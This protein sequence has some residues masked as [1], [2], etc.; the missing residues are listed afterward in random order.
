MPGGA[1]FPRIRADRSASPG[2]AGTTSRRF[3][4][5]QRKNGNREEQTKGGSQTKDGAKKKEE[6]RHAANK[7]SV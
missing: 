3:R 4:E 5:S 1:C 2:S 7:A 6:K